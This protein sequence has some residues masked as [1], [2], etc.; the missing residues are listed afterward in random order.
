MLLQPP[1][2]RRKETGEWQVMSDDPV[3]PLHVH[4]PAPV[5]RRWLNSA[6]YLIAVLAIAGLVFATV[7]GVGG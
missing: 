2:R 1:A 6:G 7:F 4:E 3:R 5:G